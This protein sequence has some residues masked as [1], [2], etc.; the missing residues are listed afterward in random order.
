MKSAEPYPPI[1]KAVNWGQTIENRPIGLER[2]NKDGL[3][4]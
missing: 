4:K 3:P 1:V 2:S